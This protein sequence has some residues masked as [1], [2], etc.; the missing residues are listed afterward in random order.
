MK[1]LAPIRACDE[2]G[3]AMEAVEESIRDTFLGRTKG[4]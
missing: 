3:M 1:I 2:L 4:Q